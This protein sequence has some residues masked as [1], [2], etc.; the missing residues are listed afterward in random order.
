MIQ[1]QSV[2]NSNINV[3]CVGT[4]VAKN[5]AARLA[6]P[7]SALNADLM[8]TPKATTKSV[9]LKTRRQSKQSS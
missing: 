9:R 5:A 2:E 4:R 3:V 8:R 7:T 6:D 1:T